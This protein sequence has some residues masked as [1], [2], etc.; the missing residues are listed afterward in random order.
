MDNDLKKRKPNR[1]KNYDYSQNGAYFITICTKNKKHIL[2]LR[3]NHSV[4][5]NIIGYLKMNSSKKIHIINPD[6]IVWQRSYHDHIIRNETDYL[7]IWEYINS[8]ALKWHN[9][10][11]Y[12]GDN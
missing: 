10:K 9:D 3:N 8:N 6:E 7:N 4:I 2:S 1:L 12:M 11:Y 5:S